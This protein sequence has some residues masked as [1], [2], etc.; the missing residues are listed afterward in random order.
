M[1]VQALSSLLH[2]GG[3]QRGASK[4]PF[5]R[6]GWQP[7]TFS[8][9]GGG[10]GSLAS[11][12]RRW[13]KS[14]EE[15]EKL[16]ALMKPD[17]PVRLAG[18]FFFHRNGSCGWMCARAVGRPGPEPNLFFSPSDTSLPPDRLCAPGHGRGRAFV[19]WLASHTCPVR[20]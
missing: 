10:A 6:V 5:R 11:A 15:Y 1:A 20:S 14:D 7:D 17:P 19:C 2:S 12:P 8:G 16:R 13:R 4:A 18:Q 9:G 3:S